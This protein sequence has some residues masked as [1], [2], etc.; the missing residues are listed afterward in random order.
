MKSKK[1]LV[2]VPAYNEQDNIVNTIEDIKANAKNVDYI[3]INDGSTDNTEK[4]LKEKKYNHINL[5]QNLG[6]FGAVQSGLK[7]A[8]Q[9]DY[10]IAIQFDGDGQ[11]MAK[12]ILDLVEQ[13]NKG[14]NIVIGSRF[15]HKKR[16]WNAR[17]IG[18]RIITFA[19]KLMTL[20][21]IKDPTSGMRAYDKGTI[22]EY[23]ND[24][25]NPPEPD[26]LVYMFY[27]KKKILEVPVE[28]RER[29]F[30][31]TIFSISHTLKYMSRVLISIFL[32]QP[33]RKR[34]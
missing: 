7:Y 28:M 30:G 25:N 1:V 26:T 27:K 2:I 12:Y 24:M 31:E 4:V 32:I 9:N 18:S 14:Y 17:M 5:I 23:A 8:S 21:T 15:V 13:I 34:K 16:P 6:L 3:V 29:V 19:I 10:D 22:K 20:E 33:F 11:H